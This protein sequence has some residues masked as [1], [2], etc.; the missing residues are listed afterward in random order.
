LALAHGPVY[1]CGSGSGIAVTMLAR[2]V[3]RMI[4]RRIV[5]VFE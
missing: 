3:A 5:V 4:E 1:P 2:R